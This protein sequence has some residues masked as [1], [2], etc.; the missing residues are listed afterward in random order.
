MYVSKGLFFPWDESED[1]TDHVI[2]KLHILPLIYFSLLSAEKN[3][4]FLHN[5]FSP[6]HSWK[7]RVPEHYFSRTHK[8]FQV[9]GA[10]LNGNSIVCQFI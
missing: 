4:I 8:Y 10:S 9:F 1:I 6:L 5:G 7:D 3:V 2:V